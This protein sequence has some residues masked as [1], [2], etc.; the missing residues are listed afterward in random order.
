MQKNERKKNHG[1]IHPKR[2]FQT[3]DDLMNA[4][5]RY[6]E[7]VKK[8]AGQWLKVQYV[9]K[10]GQRVTDGQMPPLTIDGFEIFCYDN[11]GM[12]EQYFNNKDGY[13]EDFVTICSRIR[14]EIR[15]NQITGGML[16]FY[17]PSITQRLNS[18]E[19]KT[20]VRT[21]IQIEGISQADLD[22]GLKG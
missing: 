4:F 9:G 13:Y 10:D 14:K 19:E 1:N 5:S 12:V 22:E 3:P 7:L 21:N 18:L 20:E 11:Y 15:T 8:Q 2:I 6:K 17:N 16:G